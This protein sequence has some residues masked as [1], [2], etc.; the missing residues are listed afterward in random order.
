[1]AASV[2]RYV[3]ESAHAANVGFFVLVICHHPQALNVRLCPVQGQ[4]HAI[5]PAAARI[6]RKG[7][8]LGVDTRSECR[9]RGLQLIG[10]RFGVQAAG[11]V[12][13]AGHGFASSRC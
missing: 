11:Q 4:H 3:I 7:I 9:Q 13:V 5:A 6:D 2:H 10:L 1:M 12:K 8:Q